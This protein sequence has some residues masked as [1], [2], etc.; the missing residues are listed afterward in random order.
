LA[1]SGFDYFPVTKNLGG[2]FGA[3]FTEDVRVAANHFFVDFADDVGDGEAAFFASNLG[4]KEDLEKEVAQF[5]SEFGVIGTFKCIE[6]LV[7][8]FDEIGAESSVGLFA[9]P[10]AAGGGTET[11]HESDEFF[12]GGTDGARTKGFRFAWRVGG[13]SRRFPLRFARSHEKF[14][15]ISYQF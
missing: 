10:R 5:F 11:S 7:R 4:V 8:F 2:V 14:S 15:L 6:D 9:I 12:E 1:L 13:A 3:L